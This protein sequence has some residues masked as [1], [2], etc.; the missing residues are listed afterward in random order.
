MDKWGV[1]LPMEIEVL[2][3]I[4]KFLKDHGY[5]AGGFIGFI[6]LI[7]GTEKIKKVIMKP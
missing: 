2:D 6:Y 3:L 5:S 4:V 7:S 1:I